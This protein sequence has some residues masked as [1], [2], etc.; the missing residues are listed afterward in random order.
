MAVELLADMV[1]NPLLDKN[2]IEAE[3]D[4]IY[5]NAS[6]NHKDQMN[7][8]LEAAHFTVLLPIL[9][10]DGYGY[11]ELQRPFPGTTGARNQREHR[12]HFTGNSQGVP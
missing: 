4:E 12:S 8:T 11:S 5:R 10:F 7:A 2:Q 3:R 9:R 6:E 1:R